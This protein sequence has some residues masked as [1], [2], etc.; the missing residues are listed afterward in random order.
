MQTLFWAEGDGL[1]RPEIAQLCGPLSAL[2][3]VMALETVNLIGNYEQVRSARG[4]WPRRGMILW[5]CHG[6]VILLGRPSSNSARQPQSRMVA[7]T[8]AARPS[9]DCTRAAVPVRARAVAGW[10]Q[11]SRPKLVQ[12]HC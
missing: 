7:L 6:F 3:D 1:P 8:P 12:P 4:I 11:L 2:L 5:A 9:V 10:T